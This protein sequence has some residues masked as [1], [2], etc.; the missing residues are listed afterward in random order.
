MK[1]DIL[2]VNFTSEDIGQRARVDVAARD[3]DYGSGIV[4]VSL[5]FCS[6]VA[7]SSSPGSTLN[8]SDSTPVADRV[9]VIVIKM[10]IDRL[11]MLS[12]VDGK[13]QQCG[14]TI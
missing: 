14:V 2:P 12:S 1:R 5:S 8:S 11:Q 10:G 3:S 9:Y 6:S 13:G 4:R 7:C